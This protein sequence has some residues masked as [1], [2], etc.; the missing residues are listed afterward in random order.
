MGTLNDLN[1]DALTIFGPPSGAAANRTITLNGGGDT[2]PGAAATDLIYLTNNASL[3]LLSQPGSTKSLL[4]ALAADGDFD[5]GPSATLSIAPVL[6]GAYNFRKTGA[7]TLTLSGA[8]TVAGAG[9]TFELSAGT[10]N[11]NNGQALGNGATAFVIDGGTRINNTSGAAI[12][13]G[14]GFLVTI[15]G[16]FAYGTATGVAANNLTLPGAVRLAGDHTLTLNGAGVLT[17]SGV[18]A[19]TGDSAQTLTVNTGATATVFSPLTLSGGYALTGAAST[20][21]RT[22]TI[23]GSG[24]VTVTGVI[25][26]GS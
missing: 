4:V 15:N 14:I 5:V 23:C 3:S 9:K 12:A 21:P 24:N 22:N 18:L 10:L 11:F 16:D 13:S 8:N 20:A 1:A 7:G 19:N 25:S 26:D 2:I 17:L 6:S